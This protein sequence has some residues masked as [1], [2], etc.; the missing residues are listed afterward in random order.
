MEY[1]DFQE[2][3]HCGGRATF[4]IRCDADGNTSVQQGIEHDRA[5]PASWL[6]VYA[7]V[8]TGQPL[9]DFV[10]GGIGDSF[11]PPA[12]PGSMAV[13]LAS[14]SQM[15]WGHQCPRPQCASY[16]RNGH[17]SAHY[18]LTCPYCGLKTAAVRFLTPKQV[19]YCRH[20]VKTLYDAVDRMKP[21][22]EERV[23]IDMDAIV[24]QDKDVPK[25]D[26]YY[27]SASQQTQFTCL[28][29]G[30]FNDIRGRFGYCASCGWR[31]NAAQFDQTM[32]SLRERLNTGQ[33]TPEGTVKSAVSE[34]D[35]CCRDFVQQLANR[36]PMKSSRV[37]E[38]RGFLFHK[39]DGAALDRLRSTFDIDLTRGM[40]DDLAF[41]KMMMARRHVFEHAGG[42]MDQKYLDESGDHNAGLGVLIR[43]SKENA[44]RLAGLLV[45]M[46]SNLDRDFHGI[47]PPTAWPV[48]YFEKTRARRAG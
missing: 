43:E 44:H 7:L 33:D 34:F 27:A 36:I 15:R 31:N 29:C 4:N 46:I 18:P 19:A 11:R 10:M 21:G 1:K 26:F 12:P 14:D 23:V 39:V 3:A 13:F 48:E 5:G 41:L 16:F 35:S 42:V 40:S 25:P 28:H 32:A 24:D 47:F 37:E 45:R 22:T 38:L 20:Y 8:A 6:G 17:H 30:D 2:I 9:L